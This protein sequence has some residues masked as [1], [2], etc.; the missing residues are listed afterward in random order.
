VLLDYV[1]RFGAQAVFG[2]APGAGELRRM[3]AAERVVSAFWARAH[4]ESWAEW[5]MEN[6]QAAELLN[7]AAKAGQNE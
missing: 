1:E 3:I 4:A 2:R 6:P 5:A 7:I